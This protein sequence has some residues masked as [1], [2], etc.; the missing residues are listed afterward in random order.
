VPCSTPE[1]ARRYALAPFLLALAPALAA[2]KPQP[3]VEGS[4]HHT[5]V[6]PVPIVHDLDLPMVPKALKDVGPQGPLPPLPIGPDTV[7]QPTNPPTFVGTT[8]PQAIGDVTLF[9]NAQAGLGSAVPGEPAVTSN[10]T[11]VLAT[12]NT[13]ASMSTDG[14]NTYTSRNLGSVW[15]AIDG[16]ICCDQRIIYVPEHDMTIWLM[17]YSYSATTQKNTYG[18]A[19]FQGQTRLTNLN[20]WRYDIT[21]QIVGYPAGR[22]FDFPD[23]AF[24][25]DHL[26]V[27]ANVY[28]GLNNNSYEDSVVFRLTLAPMATGGS[29]GI[30][31]WQRTR[32]L[33]GVGS[34]Y[35]FS[36]GAHHA[37]TKMWWADHTSTTQLS[38]WQ[39]DD[40]SG[41]PT[42]VDVAIASFNGGGGSAPGPDGREWIGANDGRI[43][44][45]YANHEEIGFLWTCRQNPPSRPLPFVRV[46]RVKVSDRSLIGE[47][48]IFGG[49]T[50]AFGYPAASTNSIGNVGVVMAFGSTTLH[51]AACSTVVDGVYGVFGG[52][53]GLLS[54]ANGTNGAPANR[55]GDYLSVEP[56]TANPLVFTGT[57]MRQNGGTSQANTESR[58]IMFQRDIYGPG[59]IAAVVV[60]RGPAGDMNV[61]I[62]ATTDSFGLGNGTT[63]LARSYDSPITYVLTAPAIH[64]HAGVRYCFKEWLRNGL[65]QGSFTTITASSSAHWV[66]SYVRVRSID[67]RNVHPT[68]NVSFNNSPA[69][70]NGVSTGVL[71]RILDFPE[72]TGITVTVPDVQASAAFVRWDVQGGSAQTNRTLVLTMN[73]DFVATAI[74]TPSTPGSWAPIGSGC[75]GSHNGTPFM[76][77]GGGNPT[78]GGTHEHQMFSAP[79]STLAWNVVGTS[80]TS[81]AGLPL[82]FDCAPIGAPGCRI[83]CSQDALIGSGTDGS[84]TAR[85]SITYPRDRALAGQTY[86][87]QYLVFDPPANQLDIIV[88]N[89]LRVTIGL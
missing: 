79:P 70:C 10:G 29:V 27:A 78:V 34:S 28:N 54:G 31:V 83:Y 64:T 38:V 21:P 4:G 18:L 12:W 42:R 13:Q 26:F 15:P 74:Y 36:Q 71:P 50:T 69:D 22:W 56:W 43:T 58:V 20:G 53:L 66:A 23:I 32:D 48:D 84:G 9:R 35:R 72:G 65:F 88:S 45:G 14:G 81:F 37:S 2:Q 52:S 7:R 41:T 86:F 85:V 77:F 51:V 24:S 40:A 5:V 8:G 82:P 3:I 33:S 62:T 55:W 30:G 49:S 59:K 19:V 6:A 11:T 46:S 17:Q 61:P 89:Y 39:L 68:V 16:G 47:A 80:N 57:Q 73:Q 76:S 44:G 87:T 1:P 60:G 25:R 63:P 75:V 67:V